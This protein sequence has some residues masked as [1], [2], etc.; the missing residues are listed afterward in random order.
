MSRRPSLRRRARGHFARSAATTPRP[1]VLRPTPYVSCSKSALATPPSSP[2]RCT[3]SPTPNSSLTPPGART[4]HRPGHRRP[5]QRLSDRERAV[6]APMA[7]AAPTPASPHACT[8][9][10]KASNAMSPRSLPSLTCRQR[11]RQPAGPSR[12]RLPEIPTLKTSGKGDVCCV[13]RVDHVRAIRGVSMAPRWLEE[14]GPAPSARRFSIQPAP[15]R[16]TGTM[17]ATFTW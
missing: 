3:G 14:P 5:L 16:H 12:R 15:S 7:E 4:G 1:R 6:L 8:S 2:T 13:W 10:P 9:A 17:P 11:R